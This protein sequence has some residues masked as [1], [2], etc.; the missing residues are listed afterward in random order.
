M[1]RVKYALIMNNRTI[2]K[3]TNYEEARMALDEKVI[4]MDER[5]KDFYELY[6]AYI[7]LNGKRG[8]VIYC[9]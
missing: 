4:D 9:F 1:E 3:F 8:R 5:G 7:K 6:I 2:Q